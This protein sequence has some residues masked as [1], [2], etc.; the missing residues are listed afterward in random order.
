[1]L[2]AQPCPTVCIPTDCSPPGSSVHRDSSGKDTVVGCHFLLQGIFPTQG[3]LGLPHCR[4][5]LYYLSHQGSPNFCLKL[6][7]I[8]TSLVVQ[9]L[10]FRAPSEGGWVQSLSEIRSYMPQLRVPSPQVR[11]LYPN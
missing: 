5:I 9:W 10:R 11:F 3:N 1:M 8:G 2:L 4:Q 7:I 6:L